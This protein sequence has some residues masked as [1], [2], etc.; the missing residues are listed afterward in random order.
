MSNIALIA[1]VQWQPV[2]IWIFKGSEFL[3]VYN[4]RE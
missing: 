4:S 1:N 3:E 2:C